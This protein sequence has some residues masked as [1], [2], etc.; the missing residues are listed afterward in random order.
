MTIQQLRKELKG[1]KNFLKP[2]SYVKIFIIHENG[3]TAEGES[4]EYID[5]WEAAHPEA[6]VFKLR[7]K[8]FR[9]DGL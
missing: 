9:V 8:S 7:C 5:A 1:I 6:Q 4:E 3:L 2:E